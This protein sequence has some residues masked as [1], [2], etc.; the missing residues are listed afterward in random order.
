MNAAL[1]TRPAP[2]SVDDLLLLV[3]TD[4]RQVLKPTEITHLRKLVAAG[5]AAKVPNGWVCA[6]TFYRA[7]T[8]RRIIALD[9]ADQTYFG[10]KHHLRPSARGRAV[11]ELLAATRAR[12][13][14]GPA[15][16]AGGH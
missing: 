12:A 3:S 6:G 11:V 1:A 8:F 9:L 14:G 7:Q 2:A 16:K 10:G 15:G 4:P 5:V 13:P